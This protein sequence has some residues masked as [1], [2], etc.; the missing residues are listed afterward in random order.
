MLELHCTEEEMKALEACFCNDTGFHYLDFL[1]QI[2]PEE[3]PQVMYVK[4]LKE[5]RLTNQKG[6]LPERNTTVADLE[7]VLLKIK[8]K[9]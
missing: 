9:V 1:N 8:S 2:Q 3:K 4:R 6:K 7:S 5:I